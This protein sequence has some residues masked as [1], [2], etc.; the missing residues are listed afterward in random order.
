MRCA[1]CDQE[2]VYTVGIPDPDLPTVPACED[3]RHYLYILINAE[4][5]GIDPEDYMPKGDEK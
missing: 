3:H 1:W 5:L 4:K 2:A